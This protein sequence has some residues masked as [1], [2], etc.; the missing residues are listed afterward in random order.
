MQNFKP[1]FILASTSKYRAQVLNDFGIKFSQLSPTVDE[2]LLKIKYS[3]LS[4]LELC[5]KLAQDKAV[6]VAANYPESVVIGS[7]QLV[8]FNGKVLGKPG[9]AEKNIE[10]LLLLNGKTHELITSI[11]ICYKNKLETATTIAKLTL[12]N[13]TESQIRGYVSQDMAIDCAGGYKI[14]KQGI[15]LM[16]S[17][18]TN[19]FTSI[20]GL[21]LLALNDCLIKLG[22]NVLENDL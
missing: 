6:S 4:P 17:I 5:K 2:D 11:C 9:T 13:L 7:D 20:K 16:Q 3:N 8:Q 19:D 22:I 21:P 12:K 10:Q 15:A 1:S 14:E 18:E